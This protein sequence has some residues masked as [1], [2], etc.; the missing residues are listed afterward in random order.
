MQRQRDKRAAQKIRGRIALV[1]EDR[2]RLETTDGR[3]L[4]LTIGPATGLSMDQLDSLASSGTLVTVI[5]KGEPDAGAV[6]LNVQ[7]D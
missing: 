5:F 7:Q 3:S 6:A 1:Q 2:F 4:L